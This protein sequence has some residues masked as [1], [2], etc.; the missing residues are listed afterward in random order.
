M[1]CRNSLQPLC[2]TGKP[3]KCIF[4]VG[5]A[6]RKDALVMQLICLMDHLWRREGLDL[7][8]LTYKIVPIGGWLEVGVGMLP[9]IT[10]C[11]QTARPG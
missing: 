9:F 6:M 4:K 10:S 7:N 8:M 11:T 5:D 3:F 1:C 2:S